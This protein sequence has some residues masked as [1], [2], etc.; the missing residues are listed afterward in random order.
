MTKINVV[1]H[2]FQKPNRY[3]YINTRVVNIKPETR[4]SVTTMNTVSDV[5]WTYKSHWYKVSLQENG[6][7][8]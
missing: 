6:D 1:H 7:R 5:L 8:H 2:R 4:D 3:R